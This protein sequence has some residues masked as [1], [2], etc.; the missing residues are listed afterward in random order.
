LKIL[1]L[2]RSLGRGGAERQLVSLASALSKRGH[3]TKIAVFYSGGALE[4]DLRKTGVPVTVMEKHGRWDI[5]SFLSRIALL[6][7]RERPDVL[8]SYLTV[9]NLLSI[10][11][12]PLHPRT[13]VVLGIRASDMD[14]NR[15]DWLARLTYKMECWLSRYADLII[16]NSHAG[17]EHASRNGFPAHKMVV[18]PNGI[19]T[20]MFHPDTHARNLIRAEWGIRV[21]YKLIGLVARLDPMKDHPTF[22]QAAS[23]LAQKRDDVYFACVGDGPSEYRAWLQEMASK[24]GLKNRIIWTGSRSDMPSVYNAFDIVTSSSS[25]GEGF[26]NAIGET[27]ACGV[28]CVVTDVGDSAAIVGQCGVV[29]PRRS[30]E[31]LVNAWIQFLEGRLVFTPSAIRERI[32]REFSLESLA[33]NTEYQLQVLIASKC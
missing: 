13:R 16:C 10:M 23:L 27:M 8:H 11:F 17:M 28:P 24:S 4:S 5:V 1:F 14:L 3:F 30:P 31:S 19:D 9:P 29:V 21:G 15:Y 18:I 32:V 22:L 33:R 20:D 7:R 2:S 25:F 12:K 26:S 6:L